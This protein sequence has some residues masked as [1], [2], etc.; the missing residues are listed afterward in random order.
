MLST[1]TVPMTPKAVGVSFVCPAGSMLSACKSL[2]AF[3]KGKAEVF[4][5]VADSVFFEC[6]GAGVYVEAFGLSSSFLACVGDGVAAGSFSLPWDAFFAFVKATKGKG[7]LSYQAGKLSASVSGSSLSLAA[8]DGKRCHADVTLPGEEEWLGADQLASLESLAGACLPA[9]AA[10]FPVDSVL[11]A[12][13]F[14][15]DDAAKE[16]LSGVYLS[17]ELRSIVG[18]D[19]HTLYRSNIHEGSGV[20]AWGAWLP[21]W[22]SSVLQAGLTAKGKKA[23]GSAWAFYFKGAAGVRAVRCWVNHSL[24]VAVRWRDCGASYPQVGQ[25]IPDASKLSSSFSFQRETLEAALLPL[26]KALKGSAGKPLADCS[27]DGET[28]RLSIEAELF[29]KVGGTRYVPELESIGI[30]ESSAV[31]TAGRFF[32][33][34]RVHE[35][36]FHDKSDKEQ[37]T[38]LSVWEAS[39]SFCVNALYLERLLK[40]WK[41]E[42]SDRIHLS[43]SGGKALFFETGSSQALLMPVLRRR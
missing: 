10:G 31:V 40:V 7:D 33:D 30:Q 38:F 8:G 13:G 25:L 1:S 6:S 16:V 11:R 26:V 43:F 18:T 27:F 19:G 22:L 32:P 20:I 3:R 29:S 34:P 14:C 23:L 24:M 17:E 15:S 28:G 41:A 12:S 5:L 21:G 4:G 39:R 35:P 42:G 2:E 36:G 37:A 9:D